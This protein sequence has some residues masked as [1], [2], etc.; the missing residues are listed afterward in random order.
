MMPTKKSLINLFAKAPFGRA[1]ACFVFTPFLAKETE[2]KE[3]QNCVFTKEIKL[4][5]F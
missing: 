5:I 2:A 1:Y 4:L 3:N